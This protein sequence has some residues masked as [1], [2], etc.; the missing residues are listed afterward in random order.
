[1]D[2]TA[3]FDDFGHSGVYDANGGAARAAPHVNAF[4]NVNGVLTAVPP[5]LRGDL[6]GAGAVVNQNNRCPGSMEHKQPDGSVPYKPSPDFNCDANQV[7][8][9]P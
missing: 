3:W 1:V 4:A 7:L 2:L 6:L 9:G 5:S 8:P